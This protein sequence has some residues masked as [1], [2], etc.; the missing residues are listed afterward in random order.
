MMRKLSLPPHLW[1]LSLPW[2]LANSEIGKARRSKSFLV[3]HK[4]RKHG[5]R[6]V[7]VDP[8]VHSRFAPYQTADGYA[9]AISA[10]IVGKDV[11]N[12]QIASEMRRG[13]LV[14]IYSL[15][16]RYMGTPT[17]SFEVTACRSV[18]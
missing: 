18:L 16:K 3:L 1:Q 5:D 4:I 17:S 2:F 6:W 13:K 8:K 10:T 7:P 11:R 14:H 15:L 9:K 12:F